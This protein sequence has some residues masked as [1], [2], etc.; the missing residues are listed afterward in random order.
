MNYICLLQIFLTSIHHLTT[1]ARQLQILLRYPPSG[2]VKE[3]EKVK[4]QCPYGPRYTLWYKDSSRLDGFSGEYYE[5]KAD[6]DSGGFYHCLSK[7]AQRRWEYSTRLEVVTIDRYVALQVDPAIVFEGDML[8]LTCR[9]RYKS[10]RKTVFTFYQDGRKIHS[11]NVPHWKCLHSIE[12]VTLK[13]SGSYHCEIGY[14]SSRSVPV[15]IH[16]LFSKPKLRTVAETEI[17]EGQKLILICFIET[18][19]SSIELQYSFYKDD[20]GLNFNSCDNFKPVGTVSLIDSGT[21]WCESNALS[22]GVRKQSDEVFLTV[23]QLF[24]KPILTT[25]L[26]AEIFE[27]QELNLACLAEIFHS[28]TLQYVFSKNGYTLNLAEGHNHYVLE[29]AR[30]DDSG[31]YTCEATTLNSEVKK[32]SNKVSISVRRISVSKPELAIHPGKQLVEGD[33]AS[34]ICSVF[35]GSIPI[36]FIFYK[37]FNEEI[38]QEKSNLRTITCEIGKVNKST[39]GNYSCVVANDV[40]EPPP[41]SEFV[42]VTVIVPVA[43]AFLILKPNKTEIESGDR[44]FLHCQLKAGTAPHFRWYLD[45]K[46]L[47][48]TSESYD[49][50][51]DGS[52]LIIN[53]FQRDHGGR[54]HCV[55]TNRGINEVIFNSTSNYIVLTVPVQGYTSAITASVPPVLIIGALF[56]LICFKLQNKKPDNS[57]TVSQPQGEA[58]R[59]GLQPLGEEQSAS[60]FEYAVVG[61]ARN[62]TSSSDQPTYCIVDGTKPAG[63]DTK[64]VA[65]LIYSVVTIKKSR[66]AGNSNGISGK[67]TENKNGASDYCVTYATLNHAKAAASLERDQ[68]EEGDSCHANIYEN[69][70]QKRSFCEL[71]RNLEMER[72]EEARVGHKRWNGLDEPNVLL[73]CHVSQGILCM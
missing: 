59:N 13:H 33:I 65:D 51:T 20:K 43:D 52:E 56:G 14:I 8:N 71:M 46:L 19:R 22:H 45:H 44:L 67:K 73:L 21:Y 26:E 38:H 24:S 2:I 3:G 25:V 1:Q 72:W 49:S 34:L 15:H 27:G 12:A 17:F 64:T 7:F 37:D 18:I 69:L 6:K 55:A 53:S 9:C 39:E 40:T 47:E 61:S 31:I 50:N 35:N 70:P 60:N 30:P 54:Y 23:K 5:T 32:L 16:E 66:D 28:D 29:K 36:T 10:Y 4:L 68:T 41:H 11:I 63:E 42:S 48:N 57:S 58:T 62:T